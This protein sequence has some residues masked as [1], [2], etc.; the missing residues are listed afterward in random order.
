MKRERQ[1]VQPHSLL[2]VLDSGSKGKLPGSAYQSARNLANR[3]YRPL[4]R[5]L[6]HFMLNKNKCN[7]FETES[8]P[9]P[10]QPEL[11]VVSEPSSEVNCTEGRAL[12]ID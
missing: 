10:S 12:R 4:I 7:Q 2:F 8:V 9:K 6:Q 1:D 3:M 11:G 5:G